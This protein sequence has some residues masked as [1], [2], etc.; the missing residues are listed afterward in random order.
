MVPTRHSVNRHMELGQVLRLNSSYL[1]AMSQM[2]I[3]VRVSISLVLLHWLCYNV[4]TEG[5]QGVLA[6]QES[7]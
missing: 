4:G 5:L 7:D 6:W 3:A 2:Q 1:T